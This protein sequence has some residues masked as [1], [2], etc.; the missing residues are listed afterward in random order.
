MRLHCLCTQTD[1]AARVH[2]TVLFTATST[3][4]IITMATLSRFPIVITNVSTIGWSAHVH[5]DRHRSML[6]MT[7]ATDLSHLTSADRGIAH[8]RRYSLFAFRLARTFLG[9][10]FGTSSFA[11]DDG[12]F[13][14]C[15]SVSWRAIGSVFRLPFANRWSVI[16]MMLGLP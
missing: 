14:R 1:D 2:V 16:S 11:E 6:A 5:L 12:S 15:S 3:N 8:I 13:A 4:V 9:R 10:L 7:T